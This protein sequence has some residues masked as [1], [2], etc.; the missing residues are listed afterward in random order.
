M[1][2][3]TTDTDSTY[4]HEVARRSVARAA[5]HLGVTG[6]EGGALDVLGA[7]LVDYLERVSVRFVLVCV[8]CGCI[9]RK[10]L[11]ARLD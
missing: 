2:T 8:G 1:A 11:I 6:M 9:G 5:L 3:S 4:I 10:A 7:V